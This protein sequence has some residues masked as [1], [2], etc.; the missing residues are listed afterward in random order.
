MYLVQFATNLQQKPL[1]VWDIGNSRS[2]V[3]SEGKYC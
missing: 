2:T 1:I 3:A